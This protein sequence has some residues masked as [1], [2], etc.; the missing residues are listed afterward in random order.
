MNTTTIQNQ[1]VT[2][3]LSADGRTLGLNEGYFAR[4]NVLDWIF[5]A[6]VIVGGLFAFARY[7][8]FMDVYEKGIL[9]G[10]MP[11]AIA[12]AWF[13]RPLRVLMLFVVGFALLGIASYQVDGGG[14]LGRADQV[15]WLKYFLSSQSAILWMSVLFFMST[16]LLARHD[17]QQRLRPQCHAGVAGLKNR[18]G[19]RRHGPDRHS[20]ALV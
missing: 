9:I 15:F 13:W 6:L 18:L 14:S 11:A 10:A 19:S 16:I 12:I 4:R 3:T 20:G 5:A 8:G 7:N 1:S 2:T 17:R